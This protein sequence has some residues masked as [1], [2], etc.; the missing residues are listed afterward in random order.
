M[1]RMLCTPKSLEARG[2]GQI[3]EPGQ[4]GSAVAVFVIALVAPASIWV[5]R[6]DWILFLLGSL[7]GVQLEYRALAR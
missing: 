4:V 3:G 5:Q 6:A 7:S 2:Y 1:I